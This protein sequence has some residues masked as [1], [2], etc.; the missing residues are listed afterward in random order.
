MFIFEQGASFD[1]TDKTL[2]GFVQYTLSDD[3]QV[4]TFN[5]KAMALLVDGRSSVGE[6]VILTVGT[7]DAAER[8]KL[9]AAGVDLI[10]DSSGTTDNRKLIVAGLDGDVIQIV[11]KEKVL[12]DQGGEFT[13]R[14][15]GPDN[16]LFVGP[17]RPE[18]TPWSR[19]RGFAKQ[20][21]LPARRLAYG[22]QGGGRRP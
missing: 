1:F 22:R 4:L 20:R 15:R 21:H 18:Q 7:F 19:C 16:Q 3:N 11:P 14:S 10:T 13:V 9:I 17:F 2:V 5:D 6:Q 8:Q 12:I